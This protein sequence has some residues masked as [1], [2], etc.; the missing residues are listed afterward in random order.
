VRQE[1]WSIKNE[2]FSVLKALKSVF[3]GMEGGAGRGFL[4][5]VGP[6]VSLLRRALDDRNGMLKALD[7]TRGVSVD[8]T[9][10]GLVVDDSLR[11]K[12]R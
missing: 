4:L 6:A 3:T 11:G 5:L 7:C 2:Q 9:T 1:E 8:E 12:E 10:D